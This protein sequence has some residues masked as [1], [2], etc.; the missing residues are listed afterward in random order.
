MRARK[1]KIEKEGEKKR[2]RDANRALLVP[3]LALVDELVL[4]I[5]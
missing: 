4:V 3:A 5:W 1:R 2:K